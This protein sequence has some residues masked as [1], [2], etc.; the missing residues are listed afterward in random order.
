[1]N[2]AEIKVFAPSMMIKMTS[3]NRAHPCTKILVQAHVLWI[4]FGSEGQRVL[5]N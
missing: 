3:Q 2:Y 1:M 4:C 5:F